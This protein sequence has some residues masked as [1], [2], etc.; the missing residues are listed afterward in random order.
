MKY[1]FDQRIDRRNTNAK[2]FDGYKACMFKDA[3]IK[4]PYEDDELIH[5]WIADMEFAVA[6]EITEAIKKRLDQK[7]YGYTINSDR[8]LYDALNSW[9]MNRYEWTF[10]EDELVISPG[11]VPAIRTLIGYIC[12]D[13]EKV[14]FNTPAYVQFASAAKLNNIDIVTSPFIKNGNGT[15][16]ID[17]IDLEKKMAKADTPVF[18]LCNPHNPTGKAYTE[19]ELEKFAELIKKYDM[20]VI[21]DEIHCDL[22]RE[23]TPSHIPLGK[24][25]P[26]YDKL[27]T[28]MSTSKSFNIA[29]LAESSIIIRNEK[30]RNTWNTSGHENIN[31]LSHEATIAAYTKGE[32]WLKCCNTYL[33]EN[34]KYLVDFVADNLPKAKVCPSQTTYLGWIDMSEYFNEDDDIELFFAHEAGVL[35]EADKAFV[36]NANRMVRINLACPRS[37]LKEGLAKMAKALDYALVS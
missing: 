12:A 21:S 9:C 25:M 32:E 26:D 27:I 33:D 29:G 16:D 15:Y 17:F 13:D 23:G 19:D 35:I 22:R 1:D 11:I 30:L 8:R 28:C 36:D 18:I 3:S 14:L 2:K 5:F 4:L 24:V 34:F 7:I 37:Y 6:P 31:P 20:W 10:D